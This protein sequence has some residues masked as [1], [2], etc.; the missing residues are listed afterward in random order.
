MGPSDE[1]LPLRSPLE[2]P[3]GARKRLRLLS[4]NAQ[5]GIHFSRPHHY[6][7]HSWKHL[8]P[9]DG[10]MTNL[11]RVARFIS[12][13]DVVGLQEMD[14]GSLRSS[15]VDLTAYLSE[16]A[17]FPHAYTRVN[18]DLGTF[19]KHAM[20]L[21]TRT[22][23][24]RVEMHRLPGPIPGRGAIEARFGLE[25]GE[26]LVLVLV[27]LALGRRARRSQLDYIAER[28]AHEPHA[29]VMGDFNCHPESRELKQLVARTGL[30]DP[31]PC[32]AT[33]PSWDPQR[34]FDHILLTPDLSVSDMRVYDVQLS[35][36]LP[37]GIEIELPG[38]GRIIDADQ[39]H[40]RVA[41]TSA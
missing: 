17:G 12:A 33:Y 24:D 2:R 15:Y 36:H 40:P 5:V 29:V 25:N 19:A 16:R 1:G 38:A 21:L 11:D 14:A 41:A 27:H 39:G 18:R 31:M 30:L 6:L 34:V 22:E 28:I 26:S 3:E 13:F 37:V 9:F 10:R 4:F 8:L 7:T 23:P 32:A 35:D 20:G